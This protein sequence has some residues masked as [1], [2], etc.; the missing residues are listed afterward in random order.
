MSFQI[1]ISGGGFYSGTFLYKIILEIDLDLFTFFTMFSVSVIIVYLDLYNDLTFSD[2]F[3]LGVSTV[4][5]DSCDFYFL[6]TVSIFFFE[7]GGVMASFTTLGFV[8][9]SVFHYLTTIPVVVT[10]DFSVSS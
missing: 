7:I 6:L 9:M 1:Y 2:L 3:I 4:L 5:L 8:I 10:N